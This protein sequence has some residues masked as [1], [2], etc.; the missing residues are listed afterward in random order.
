[1]IGADPAERR[2][3]LASWLKKLLSDAKA[4][5]A[6]RQKNRPAPAGDPRDPYA[7]SGNAR[8]AVWNG[9]MRDARRSHPGGGPI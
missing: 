7:A 5:R 6:A 1:M 9:T 2:S 3:I 4:K 8:D